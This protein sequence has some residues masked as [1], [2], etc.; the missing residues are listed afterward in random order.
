MGTFL[1][2]SGFRLCNYALPSPEKFSQIGQSFREVGT[3]ANIFK[4]PLK[5]NED[6]GPMLFPWT[7]ERLFFMI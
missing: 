1:N 3:C 4:D 2:R 5:T 6:V 7:C